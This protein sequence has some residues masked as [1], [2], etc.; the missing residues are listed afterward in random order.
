MSALTASSS[1]DSALTASASTDSA[2]TASAST[3]PSST[4]PAL[5]ASALTASASTASDL[6]ASAKENIIYYANKVKIVPEVHKWHNQPYYYV[7]ADG[8]TTEA[9][10][11]G[12][13]E[14]L[15]RFHGEELGSILSSRSILRLPEVHHNVFGDEI[16]Y[17]MFRTLDEVLELRK[18]M[19]KLAALMA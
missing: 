15:A 9:R 14:F 4:D 5:T 3:D 10:K 7:N 18:L 19:N 16:T 11:F 17:V 8:K 2:L 13:T 12:G 6:I 1:T